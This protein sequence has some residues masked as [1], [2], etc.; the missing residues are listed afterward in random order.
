[1]IGAGW[2]PA[3]FQRSKKG[4]REALE[5]MTSAVNDGQPEVVGFNNALLDQVAAAIPSL[6]EEVSE[7]RAA[8]AEALAPKEEPEP[9]DVVPDKFVERFVNGDPAEPDD[10]PGDIPPKPNP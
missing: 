4:L 3:Q 8:A 1:M 2:A 5:F 10:F 7:L 6:A 9:D